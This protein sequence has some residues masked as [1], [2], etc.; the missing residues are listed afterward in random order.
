MTSQLLD[1]DDG[2]L[3][4]SFLTRLARLQIAS[5]RLAESLRRGR[6]RTRRAGGGVEAIDVRAYSPGDDLRRIDWKA[7]ARFERLLVR[8]VAEESPLR[9]ALV[10]DTSASMGYG[11]PT[12]LR[13]AT[14]VAAGLAAVALGAEDRAAALSAAD[15]PKL[16]TRA[17]GGRR[18][19]Q[20]LLMAL[21]SL[22]LAGA[23]HLASAASQ[24]TTA[25]GG[26]GLCVIFSDLLD[27]SGALSGARALRMRGHEVALVEVLTPFELEPPDLSGCD[28][29]DAET[30]ELL[31]LPPH[32]ALAAY[33]EAIAEHRALLDV[34]A[35][36]L[37]VPV[38]RVST[39]DAFDDVVGM[40]LRVGLLKGAGLAPTRAA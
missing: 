23:T 40:A 33:R 10:V 19:L 22:E 32:G 29:E 9:L 2:L 7:Y 18:G 39:E 37:D 35:A 15:D 13:Q 4:P 3:S 16:I 5:R 12:K 27:P 25:L 24:A 17:S 26:R 34:E 20:R 1:A 31:E 8:V 14:R 30:G 11:T 6:R 21:D 28:L 38:L 36:E